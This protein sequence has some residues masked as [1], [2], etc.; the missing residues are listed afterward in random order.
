MARS[1]HSSRLLDIFSPTHSRGAANHEAVGRRLA[2]CEC[3][4]RTIW[5]C[6][7]M[8]NNPL[9]ILTI[10]VHLPLPFSVRILGRHDWCHR[11]DPAHAEAPRSS[12]QSLRYPVCRCRLFDRGR[13]G[14]REHQR[15]QSSQERRGSAPHGTDHGRDPERP[16]ARHAAAPGHAPRGRRYRAVSTGLE[17][18]TARP[19]GW[20]G[21]RWPRWG[22]PRWRAR[23]R[24]R[25]CGKAVGRVSSVVTA[26]FAVVSLIAKPFVVPIEATSAPRI[27]LYGVSEP[28][29]PVRPFCNSACPEHE[30]R[31]RTSLAV[32]PTAGREWRGEGERSRS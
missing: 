11:I 28:D 15:P 8:T 21:P 29:N 13:H 4:A 31:Q 3:N 26:I 27:Y 18:W 6:K 22:T 17:T 1:D 9:S 30:Q 14:Q 24:D 19:K 10:S 12:Q 23:P 16:D 32:G 7:C 2:Q 5:R 25:L 20:T